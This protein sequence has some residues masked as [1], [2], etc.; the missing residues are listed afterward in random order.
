MSVN[1]VL[2][3]EPRG[4]CAGVEMAIKALAWM[5]RSF[6]PPVYCYHEIVHNQLIVDRFERQGV[7]FVDD[8]AEVPPGK[9]IML[10]AHGSAPEVVA[11]A[12]ARGSYV[13]DSVCPLV[14]KVHHEVKVRAGKGYRI[15]YV[16]HEG[17]EEAVGTMAVAPGSM[18]RVES[19]AEVDA[20]PEFDEPVALLA[21][22]TLSHRDWQDVAV[23]VG[24]RFPE[25]W[26][27][28]RSDLC[29]AT[30][31]RQS[32]L[33]AMAT[34][35]DAIVVIGSA[36]SSNTR[37]LEKLAVEAGCQRVFRI[38]AAD[39]LPAD[40]SGTVGVTAGAS[41]PE[42]LVDEVIRAL[43][44]TGGVEVVRVT[45][46]DEYFPPPRNIRDLQTAIEAASTALLG[47]SI[48]E[49]PLMDDRSLG[50]SDVLAALTSS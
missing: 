6:E 50:A 27:P 3:A 32:A 40:L 21:Q 48:L 35:C 26:T 33:M 12:R 23:R 49:R 22:T 34:R 7:V 5:V 1:R 16:G 39:E 25:V 41:A 43:A 17:H 14:T 8:I 44:P 31:N 28:G 4:F 36:N 10:S 42:E 30:T 29:F 18:S 9:P 20:L 11:A 38:N 45:D 37:A 13:V 24:E 2:L 19:V 46:E 47:G 15:V